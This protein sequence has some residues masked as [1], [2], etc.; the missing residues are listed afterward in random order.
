MEISEDACNYE[1]CK[2]LEIS[3]RK[4]VQEE[5]PRPHEGCQLTCSGCG[6]VIKSCATLATPWSVAYQAPLSMAFS[7]QEYWSG[8][9]F[10]SPGELLD[11]VIKPTSPTLAD[12]FFITG[13]LGK[14]S[15]SLYVN[16]KHLL[17]NTQVTQTV[18]FFF[19]YVRY[20]EREQLRDAIQNTI[21]TV[22]APP[23]EAVFLA[24]SCPWERI[25]FFSILL[26]QFLINMYN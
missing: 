8:Q 1:P 24:F 11:G 17:H 2:Y 21:K 3:G 18:F 20:L 6:L 23:C 4:V 25:I 19:L 9:P 5:V 22:M 14:P 7:R 12:G 16:Y 10:P 15:C 13:P 26:A